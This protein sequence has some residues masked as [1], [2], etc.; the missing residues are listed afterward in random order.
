MTST[1]ERDRAAIEEL[2]FMYG[3]GLDGRSAGD[4]DIFDRCLTPDAQ[5]VYEFGSWTGLV[6][7]KDT[8]RRT[9]L[10]LFTFTHHMITNPIIRIEGDKAVAEYK[11]AGAHGVRQGDRE[12]VIW[13]GS[14]YR[15]DC[16]RTAAGWRIRRHECLNSWIADDGGLMANVAKGFSQT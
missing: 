4:Q 8:V 10:K 1:Y 7:H 13:G 12:Q 9:L 6:A 11:V 14:I 5:I 16:V 15:H 3:R 2:A